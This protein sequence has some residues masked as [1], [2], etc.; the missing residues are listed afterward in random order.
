MI[1][2]FKIFEKTDYIDISRLNNFKVGDFVYCINADHSIALEED[3]RYEI[4]QIIQGDDDKDILVLRE[5]LHSH[6]VETRFITEA[7]YD[8]IEKLKKLL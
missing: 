8:A 6:F 4:L 1:T 7:E 5:L 3:K 2:K